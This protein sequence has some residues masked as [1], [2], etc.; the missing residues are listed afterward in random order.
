MT[1]VST[2]VGSL[3]SNNP[4]CSKLVGWLISIVV[5]LLFLIV[6]MGLAIVFSRNHFPKRITNESTKQTFPKN[7]S[8]SESEKEAPHRTFTTIND[9]PFMAA[10]V[11]FKPDLFLCSCTILDNRHLLTAANCLSVLFPHLW[12]RIGSSFW[13]GGGDLYEVERFTIH[14]N[15]STKTFDNN[16]AVV[17]TKSKMVFTQFAQ[18]VEITIRNLSD[19][20]GTLVGWG[21][22]Y[23]VF[24]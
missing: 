6:A 2:S 22:V 20:D 8:E 24:L 4:T 18:A 10:L 7:S 1:D 12:V 16:L 9:H 13:D 19:V 23:V 3:Q 17:R 15:Y 5:C 14:H 21:K 11:S